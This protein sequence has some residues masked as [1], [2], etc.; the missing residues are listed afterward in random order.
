[1]LFLI[2]NVIHSFGINIGPTR[3]AVSPVGTLPSVGP[4]R[5]GLQHAH[6]I[7]FGFGANRLSSSLGKSQLV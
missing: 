1:M 7:S 6:C 5:G 2:Y 4:S 3:V